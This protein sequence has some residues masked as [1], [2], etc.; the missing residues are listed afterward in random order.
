[1][2][3]LRLDKKG[4]IN[5]GDI[6]MIETD[7]KSDVYIIQLYKGEEVYNLTGKTVELSILEKK[8]GYGDTFDLPIYEATTGKIKLEVLEGMTKTDGL[9]YFQ[10][11]VKDSTGLV[12]NFPIFPVEI[13]NSL[14]DDIIGT[15]VNSPYM[16]IL[17]DAVA[18]AEGAVDIV[19]DIKT[20]YDTAKTN[21][22]ADYTQT[23]TALQKDY[24]KTKT[25]L[26]TDYVAIKNNIQSDYNATKTNIQ[27]DYNSLR[28]VIMDE[29]ASAELQGQINDINSDLDNKANQVDLKTLEN[30]MD[31]F[32]T[33]PEQSVSSV[34]DAE[35][36]DG[37]NGADGVTYNNI[38]NAIRGQMNKKQ[39]AILEYDTISI[40]LENGLYNNV[41]TVVNTAKK[42]WGHIKLV[43]E[44][45]TNYKISCR[46]VNGEY[47]S[48]VGIDS[49]GGRHDI[50]IGN[51]R[52]V[53]D[54]FLKSIDIE[55]YVSLVINTSDINT[56]PIIVKKSK[57]I[58]II[59]Y[60]DDKIA[61]LLSKKNMLCKLKGNTCMIRFKYSKTKDCIILF[62]DYVNN[63]FK[64]SHIYLID[65]AT[66]EIIWDFT[67]RDNT[68]QYTF[69]N[70]E[71]ISPYKNLNA[72]NNP[73]TSVT[74]QWT[75]GSHA[76]GTV[77]T[78]NIKSVKAYCD[79][80]EIGQN[81]DTKCNSIKIVCTTE[82]SGSNTT[83]NTFEN[84]RYVLREIQ[85]WTI[86]PN[87]FDVN[88]SFEFLE[89]C[90]LGINYG[91]QTENKG[92]TKLR[93]YGDS[94]NLGLVNMKAYAYGSNK[95]VGI[96]NGWCLKDDKGNTLEVLLD[97][98][99]KC[100][101]R[102]LIKTDTP[103]IVTAS[104]GKTYSYIVSDVSFKT[105]DIVEHRGKYKF[106]YSN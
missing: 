11:T 86:T 14:K 9:F 47:A 2:I 30:R 20:D 35:L 84:N 100:G 5:R 103:T 22:Q 32:V 89:D 96:A 1:M 36:V 62:T 79:G 49:R 24:D 91:L 57:Q 33:L 19:N 53:K 28:K 66:N 90:T 48:I 67:G 77:K 23:K 68:T 17:L 104:Y 52:Y 81:I 87:T 13:K 21:L 92:F 76:I 34:G 94:S 102:C 80:V 69:I 64:L 40:T 12:D 31:S 6:N 75:G 44:K 38:G 85:E 65:N 61:P 60:I 7:N 51:N 59:K 45:D 15:V 93:H 106:Y 74:D 43:I 4:G 82:V 16:Q 50:L 26:Q 83:A 71:W 99:Y 105:G 73:I 101:N 63:C 27:N 54:Y 56:S 37:R 78:N 97:T 88:V 18:K 46:G 95:T 55:D 58:D 72:V 3:T 39:D 42:E 98:T 41:T 29:N 25:S 10:I 8:R 70:S